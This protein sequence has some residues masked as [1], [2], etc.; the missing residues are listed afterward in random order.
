MSF[1]RFLP[2]TSSRLCPSCGASPGRSLYEQRFKAPEEG[3][4]L[5]GYGVYACPNCGL[6][7]ASPLPSQSDFDEYYARLSKYEY[8]GAPS[9]VDLERYQQMASMIR[10][11]RGTAGRVLDIGCATGWLMQ[12]LQREGFCQVE[13]IEPSP[14]AAA[15]ACAM[16]LSVSI[17]TLWS[18]PETSNPWDLLILS[19]VLEHVY[20]LDAAIRKL[21]SM[22]AVEGHLFLQLP[23]ASRFPEALDAP[24]QEFSLEH[25]NFFGPVSLQALM[26]RYGFELVYLEQSDVEIHTD[27]RLPEMKALF[28]KSSKL[29]SIP[30]RDDATANAL[31]KYVSQSAKR[32]AVLANHLEVLAASEQPILV[33]GVGSHI[34]HLLEVTAL[35][36][37]SITAFL[38]SNPRYQG[39]QMAGRPILAPSAAVDY[40]EP[41]L[42]GSYQ[43]QTE[44]EK[45][46]R[47]TLRL[48][49]P[50]I[51]LY[52]EL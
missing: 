15:R 18:P 4:L 27:Q 39:L 6:G 52:P 26:A 8:S 14:T 44:I 31:A 32:E 41:I 9:A 28:Q 51:R 46:L 48:P 45:I 50:V 47:D 22:I 3:G 11:L 42:I 35:S 17:G 30:A 20:D 10:R 43:Y 34:Q 38:D 29:I 16:G 33:W 7:Y 40:P 21:R 19:A 36:R 12:A 25:I 5:A 23:D 13:G 2:T 1:P 24:F 37:C 49:N